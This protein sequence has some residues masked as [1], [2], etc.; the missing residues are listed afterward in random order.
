MKRNTHLL[1]Q[2]EFDILII[3][4]GVYGAW[5]ARDAA[6][7]GLKVALID[8]GDIC[9]QTSHSSL[10]IIHG[11]IRYLQHLD[12]R[13]TLESLQE[14][15]IWLTVAPHLVKPIKSVMPTYGHGLRG[16][17]VMWCGI[18]TYEILGTG[19]NRTIP[20]YRRINKGKVISRND[21]IKL[22]PGVKRDNLTGAAV[23]YDAQVF[24]ADEAVV[25]IADSATLHGAQ[26]AN[27]LSALKIVTNGLKVVGVEARDE[28]TKDTFNIQARLVIN[29]AGPWIKGLLSTIPELKLERN[30]FP[31]TKSMN[32]VTT[33]LFDDFAVAIQS[34]RKSDSV[35]GSTRRLYFFTPWENRTII[36]T[37]HFPYNCN[38][39]DMMIS[40]EEVQEFIT[41]INEAYAGANLS[42]KDVQ[43]C[44]KGLTPSDE[45]GEEN[46]T[47]SNS[48]RSHR[49]KIL[50][51][52]SDGIEGLLSVVGVKYTTARLEAERA[53]DLA[54]RKLGKAD[55]GCQ[56]R[57]LPLEKN[58]NP[59]VKTGE[60]KLDEFKKFCQ[61]QID[62]NMTLRF[63]DLLLRRMHLTVCG[64]I[65]KDKILTAL[66]VMSDNY[67]WNKDQQIDELNNFKKIWL[68]E[69]L[70]QHLEDIINQI[71]QSDK[72]SI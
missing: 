49:S 46:A 3:G 29:S 27:Y 72:P 25:E 57:K 53:V 43:Y 45:Q 6:L 15:K 13:R 30:Q 66:A 48:N 62:H 59:I 24:G 19:R 44:Y 33:R 69:E 51:H 61:Y 67:D 41:E 2:Q 32:L 8:R 64:D 34:K 56:T 18:K 1:T 14:Q 16:P 23:W 68:N 7:R 17:E 21:C 63:S 35:V 55:P 42:L 22:V 58:A 28:I 38:P 65:S 4:A 71:N 31:L 37:T 50:D 70:N 5:I 10:K 20:E 9:G 40:K 47:G 54:F 12:I 26:V 11:G 52:S 60:L 36:G 39:D